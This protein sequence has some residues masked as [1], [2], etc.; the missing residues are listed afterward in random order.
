MEDLKLFFI[1]FLPFAFLF[2]YHLYK[3]TGYK[4]KPL[5]G[6]EKIILDLIT[7]GTKYTWRKVAISIITLFFIFLLLF[8]FVNHLYNVPSIK[9]LFF[10]F[11]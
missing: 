2:A 5:T 4:F 1:T 11:L 10:Y 7:K 6:N 8:V 3:L 9:L